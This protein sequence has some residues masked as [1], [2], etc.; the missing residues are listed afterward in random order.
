MIFEKLQSILSVQLN[1]D[2]NDI[3]F[4]TDFFKDLNADSLD[5]I[6]LVSTIS[7]EFDLDFDENKISNFKTV[8]D[9]VKYIEENTEN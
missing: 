7:G 4:D 5:I 8:G 6:D 9:V 3:S 1:V 2:K